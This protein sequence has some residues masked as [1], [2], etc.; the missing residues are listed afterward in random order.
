M[1][2][3]MIE[4]LKANP[5]KIV[6]TEGHDARILEAAARLNE[7]G[8]LTPILVG[9]VEEVKANAAKG[10]F[11]IDGVEILDPATYAGMDEMVENMVALRKGTPRGR[12]CI[13]FEAEGCSE[14]THKKITDKCTYYN[15]EHRILPVSAATMA[16]ALGRSGELAVVGITDENLRRAVEK[17][18][19][20]ER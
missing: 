11:N 2:Q 12:V 7:G 6:F 15:I 9:N 20:A 5:R 14:N 3:G 10:G 1:F 17:Q 16:A 19:D 13:V 8:F 4:V 18:L